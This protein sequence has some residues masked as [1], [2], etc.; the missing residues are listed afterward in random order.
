[1]HY[2]IQTDTTGNIFQ[3]P[4]SVRQ[5][6]VFLTRVLRE[7]SSNRLQDHEQDAG[8]MSWTT[9][10]APSLSKFK[11]MAGALTRLVAGKLPYRLPCARL[12]ARIIGD[13]GFCKHHGPPWFACHRC[14][15]LAAQSDSLTAFS[16]IKLFK[17]A[18]EKFGSCGESGKWMLANAFV[19]ALARY[20]NLQRLSSPMGPKQG[21]CFSKQHKLAQQPCRHV[22]YLLSC[23]A[24]WR[25]EDSVEASSPI[26]YNRPADEQ[27]IHRRLYHMDPAMSKLVSE[28]THKCDRTVC[29]NATCD[30]M[31]HYA[32][33]TTYKLCL[34]E[35]FAI[36]LFGLRCCSR[37]VVP[38]SSLHIAII[39]EHAR[40]PVS[41]LLPHASH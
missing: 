16:T 13:F 21:V 34:V 41:M 17:I 14:F 4:S 40:L 15:C 32:V 24:P 27:S 38:R 25:L 8:C 39:L 18:I 10:C 7:P 26:F 2:K 31:I 11:D 6:D 12:V 20:C 33:G 23:P 1:M 37:N 29:Q 3:F 36:R 19:S 5:L 22:E 9:P 30:S 35:A 28:S